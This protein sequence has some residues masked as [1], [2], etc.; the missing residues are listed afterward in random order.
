MPLPCI[1][2]PGP[3]SCIPPGMVNPV[4]ERKQFMKDNIYLIGF[5]GSGKTAVSRYL[6]RHYGFR[7]IEMDDQI[8]SMAGMKI[9]EIFRIKGEEEFRRME[10]DLLTR[11]AGE[12]GAVVSCGG[13][14]A[15]RQENVR[16]MKA[17][18]TVVYLCASAPTILQRVKHSSHR[19]L[20]EG[21]KTLE[22]IEAFLEK[23]RPFYENAADR[24][25][26]VDSRTLG[27]IS[28]DIVPHK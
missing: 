13:G 6:G 26:P 2:R 18:G 22:E 11:I 21:H 15:V 16:I 5:M 8:E 1:A 4:P 3:A 12:G 24:T 28:R 10:T 17:S 9:S 7:V 27:E 20:L 23:R 14:T 19:P 25:V